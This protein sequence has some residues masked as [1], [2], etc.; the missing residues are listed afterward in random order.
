MDYLFSIIVPIYNAERYINE[1]IESLTSQLYNNPY[2]IVLVDDGSRDVSYNIAKK[3]ADIH[4]NITLLR[5]ENGGAASARALGAKVA[6]GEYI[7][8]IDSDDKL[9]D[10]A[11]LQLEKIISKHEPDVIQFSRVLF[12]DD[13]KEKKETFLSSGLYNKARIENE[14]FPR[15]FYDSSFHGLPRGLSYYAIRRKMYKEFVKDVQIKIAEDAACSIPC[16][17]YADTVYALDECI[18]YVRNNPYST[19][20]SKQVFSWDIPEVFYKHVSKC[21]NLQTYDFVSQMDRMMLHLIYHVVV[22]QFNLS[23]DYKDIKKTIIEN[24]SLQSYSD[25]IDKVKTEKLTIKLM[26]YF[27]KHRIILPFWI[28]N[29]IKH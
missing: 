6:K 12:S 15:L 17:Y 24:L 7:L 23:L 29:R 22:S 13:G 26:V 11:L 16:L 18:L 25:V 8:S 5:K 2:E 10:D 14:I 21:I 28:M 20:R 9:R 1:C 19:T 4:E 3:Y 27:L